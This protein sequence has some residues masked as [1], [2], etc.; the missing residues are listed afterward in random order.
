M[1]MFLLMGDVGDDLVGIQL[2][3]GKRAISALPME[4]PELRPFGLNPFRRTDLD[5]LHHLRNG[6]GAR[7][8]EEQVDVVLHPAD[9]QRWAA[10]RFEHRREIGV[11]LRLDFRREDAFTVFRAEDE[12]G[13]EAGEGLG[14]GV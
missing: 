5:L 10:G 7:Q 6:L 14:H 8:G 12:V 4:I 9:A 13:Q 1:V 11:Q 3:D 2:T